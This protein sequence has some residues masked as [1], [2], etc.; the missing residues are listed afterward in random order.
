MSL[1]NCSTCQE[2]ETE[3]LWRLKGYTDWN[4]A[5]AIPQGSGVWRM[6]SSP[7]SPVGG[8]SVHINEI[9]TTDVYPESIP[10]VTEQ[11]IHE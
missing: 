6:A 10:D 5:Y 8:I 1:K 3:I 2:K 11:P 4:H 7:G 9:E